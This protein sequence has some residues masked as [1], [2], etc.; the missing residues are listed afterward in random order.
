MTRWWEAEGKEMF[1]DREGGLTI[2]DMAAGRSV[3]QFMPWK[4][5]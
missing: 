5:G 4:E 1:E 2:L 3:S